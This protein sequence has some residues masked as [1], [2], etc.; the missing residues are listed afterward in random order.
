VKAWLIDTG[1]L[2]AY[3]NARDP[4]HVEVADR[5][6]SFAGQLYT[7][8]AV[9]TEVMHFVSPSP[10]GPLLLAELVTA[11]G[12]IVFDFTQPAALHDAVALMEKYS[13]TPMD[14]ADAT[15]VLLGEKLGVDE[16]LTLDRRGFTVFRMRD[17][18]AFC[19]VLDT[20]QT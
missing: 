2:V 5:L 12:L 4:A 3:L 11:S 13:G 17:R 7:T 1:P 6:D 20:P 9:I 15:L 14:F 8:S 19:L 18:G 10:A 16:I